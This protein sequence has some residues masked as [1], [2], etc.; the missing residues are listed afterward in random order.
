MPVE[1]IQGIVN[2]DNETNFIPTNWEKTYFEWM[3]QYSTVVYFKTT[4][5]GTSEF[6]FGTVPDKHTFV[7]N[8]YDGE[9]KAERQLNILW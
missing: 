2:S 9:A 4:I 1:A 8:N 7:A 3:E 5:M 6:Q